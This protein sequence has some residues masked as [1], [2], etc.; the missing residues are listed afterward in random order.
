MNYLPENLFLSNGMY[1]FMLSLNNHYVVSHTLRHVVIYTEWFSIEPWQQLIILALIIIN[2]E[3]FYNLWPS[4]SCIELCVCVCVCGCGNW[5]RVVLVVNSDW[6]N[7]WWIFMAYEWMKNVKRRKGMMD[8]ACYT[9]QWSNVSYSGLLDEW[10]I[11]YLS[12][13]HER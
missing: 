5:K 8:N 3:V 9:K 10:I 1:I 11:W 7:R 13:L 2:N 6:E 12:I 4:T